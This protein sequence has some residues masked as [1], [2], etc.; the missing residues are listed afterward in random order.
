MK[1]NQKPEK[2][3]LDHLKGGEAFMPV[4]KILEKITWKDLGERPQSLPYSFYELFYHMYFTQKDILNYCLN[5]NYE[6]PQW[7]DDYWPLKKSPDTETEW[8]QLKSAFFKD[9]KS[10]ADLLAGNGLADTVPSNEE[11]SFFREVLLV[12]E[13]NAYHSGQLVILLRLLGLHSA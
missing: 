12:L 11:H 5:E 8:E 7:P 4:E 6:A 10:L 13:H 1:A 9:R 3:L 2:T